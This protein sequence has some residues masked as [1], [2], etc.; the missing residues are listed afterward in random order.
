VFSS[1]EEALA[2]IPEVRRRISVLAATLALAAAT[3]VAA[4]PVHVP[5]DHETTIAGVGVG[6]TGVGQTKND[7]KWKAYAV[8]VEFAGP[9][10]EYL[11]NTTLTVSDAKGAE[12]L[13][14]FCEGP[15][16]LLQLPPGK[17]YKV[18]GQV[19]RAADHTVSATVKPPAHGQARVVLNF[20]GGG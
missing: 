19:G 17:S 13:E 3:S 2:M 6:C 12:V 4:Q 11:A 1:A 20:S 15:W 7:P 16:T 8:L 18:V 10:G 9:G 5:L 14:A